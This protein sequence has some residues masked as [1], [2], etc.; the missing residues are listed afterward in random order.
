MDQMIRFCLC[1][2]QHKD[3][4][5]SR[6]RH[7]EERWWCTG[8]RLSCFVWEQKTQQFFVAFYKAD[9][10]AT[11]ETHLVEAKQEWEGVESPSHL[12][13][14]HSLLWRLMRPN[15]VKR[16]ALPSVLW[17]L[18]MLWA[19][20]LWWNKL[21]SDAAKNINRNSEGEDKTKSTG[22][23][24]IGW[25]SSCRRPCRLHKDSSCHGAS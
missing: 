24:I 18:E 5:F 15:K 21:R 9:V 22:A 14:A 1:S 2:L 7:I 8:Q 10:S 13:V 4:L 23:I 19:K 16:S 11:K 3:C 25:C 12:H 20:V 17:V 6:Q